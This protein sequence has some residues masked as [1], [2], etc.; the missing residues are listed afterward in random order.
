MRRECP[1]HPHLERQR[2]QLAGFLVARAWRCFW[3]G[4]VAPTSRSASLSV[5]RPVL[6]HGNADRLAGIFSGQET[7]DAERVS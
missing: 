7:L 2:Q 4:E 6:L 5:R 1:P 3:A